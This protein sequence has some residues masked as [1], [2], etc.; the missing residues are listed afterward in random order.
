MANGSLQPQVD[1]CNLVG[2]DGFLTLKNSLGWLGNCTGNQGK[3]WETMGNHGF[4]HQIWKMS[5]TSRRFVVP[6][7]ESSPAAVAV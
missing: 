2:A 5:Q 6:L 4:D 1:R 7:S 3:P